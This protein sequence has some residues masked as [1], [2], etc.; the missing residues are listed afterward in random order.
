MPR[1]TI[2]SRIPDSFTVGQRVSFTRT[3]TDGDMALFIGAT[4]DINPYHTDDT[5]AA[6]T[7]FKRRIVPGLLPASMATH[8]GGLWGF[9]ATE[10]NLEFVAPV[11]VGDTV[12]LEIEITAVEEPRSWYAQPLP[13]R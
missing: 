2:T 1:P 13:L 10:M 12:T 11:Y 3:F 5:F 6:K 9:L 4:W 8:L 7:R